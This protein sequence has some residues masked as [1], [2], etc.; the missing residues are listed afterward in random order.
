MIEQLSLDARIDQQHAALERGEQDALAIAAKI[1]AI[2]GAEGLL[3][4]KR[5]YGEL[6]GLNPWAAG[7][8]NMTGQAAIIRA[9]RPFAAWLAHQAGKSIPP[10]DYQAQAQ[11]ERLNA[12]ARAMESKVEQMR[13][14]RMARKQQ[15]EFQRTH[16]RRTPTGGWA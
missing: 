7:H 15:A 9:D 14:Q 16:G 2:P 6:G 1:K 5:H 10:V 4:R 3:K 12:S 13:Q 11:Q 8:E